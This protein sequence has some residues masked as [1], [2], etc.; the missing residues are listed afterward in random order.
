MHKSDKVGLCGNFMFSVCLFGWFSRNFHVFH[1]GCKTHFPPAIISIS[2]SS[3]PSRYLLFGF[4]C[5]LLVW[6]INL[7]TLTILTIVRGNSQ[8]F[9]NC[10][11]LKV[12]H[13]KPS[14]KFFQEIRIDNSKFHENI[15]LKALGILWKHADQ[16][17]SYEF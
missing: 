6:L 3:Y 15:E 9:L 5:Y 17:I 12:K 1:L 7:F 4:V 14:F 13:V 8:A 16:A 2:S 11:S 10:I